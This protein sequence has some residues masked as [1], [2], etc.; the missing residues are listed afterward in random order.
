MSRSP[1]SHHMKHLLPVCFPVSP[2]NIRNLLVLSL[3]PVRCMPMDLPSMTQDHKSTLINFS[4]TSLAC[5]KYHSLGL[6]AW[7]GLGLSRVA[8]RD[9]E[10]VLALVYP[11]SPGFRPHAS[12]LTASTFN[13]QQSLRDELGD[14]MV[15]P[16]LAGIWS[17][18]YRGR[19]VVCSPSWPRAAV[20]SGKYI[21]THQWL[22]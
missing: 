20:C 18:C 11:N 14:L 21:P 15:G 12:G 16:K 5:F 7:R 9:A 8:S 4:K 17:T 3:M 1:G 10:C 19:K 6:V 22:L 13:V 2:R